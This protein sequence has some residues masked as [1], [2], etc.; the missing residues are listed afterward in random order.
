VPRV[1]LRERPSDEYSYARRQTH[2]RFAIESAS[3]HGQNLSH[4]GPSPNTVARLAEDGLDPLAFVTPTEGPPRG[5]GEVL[6]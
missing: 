5:L 6:T 3:R 2:I 1:T 4:D